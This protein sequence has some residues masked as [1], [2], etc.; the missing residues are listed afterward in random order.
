MPKKLQN[1]HNV[2]SI[3]PPLWH[4]TFATKKQG[5]RGAW[6]GVSGYELLCDLGLILVCD[7]GVCRRGE[8]EVLL[9]PILEYSLG[10]K[11]CVKVVCVRVICGVKFG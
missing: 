11:W 3:R 2:G 10:D 9:P 6:E 1:I 4:W 5:G 8:C 7:S